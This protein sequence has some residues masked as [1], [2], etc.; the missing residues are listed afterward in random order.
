M[1]W[2]EGVREWV[3]WVV[4]VVVVV[5]ELCGWWWVVVVPLF[6]SLHTSQLY[7][8]LLGRC[9]TLPHEL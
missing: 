3:G 1:E 9:V 5:V 2:G 8:V 6:L 7:I 4:V